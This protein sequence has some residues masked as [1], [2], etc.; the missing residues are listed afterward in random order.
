[1]SCVVIAGI[2]P[3]TL[4]M[5]RR[6]G[7][8]LPFLVDADEHAVAL[9]RSHDFEAEAA[10]KQTEVAEAVRLHR[11]GTRRQR[12]GELALTAGQDYSGS[13]ARIVRRHRRGRRA[14]TRRASGTKQKFA[15]G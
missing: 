13:G 11:E 5:A 2:T 14:M 6:Y 15:R 7:G 9:A 4:E 8:Y 10:D 12:A 3:V 1:M